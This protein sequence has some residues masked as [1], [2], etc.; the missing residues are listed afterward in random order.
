L[1]EGAFSAAVGSGMAPDGPTRDELYEQA[2]DA[3][4]PGRSTMTKDELAA[5][6]DGA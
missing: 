4:I 6:L 1:A 5:A 2:K 3:D